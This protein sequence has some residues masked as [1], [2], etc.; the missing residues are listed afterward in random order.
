MEKIVRDSQCQ[1]SVAFV[2]FIDPKIGM[3]PLYRIATRSRGVFVNSALFE[4]F[5]LTILEASACGLPVVATKYGG[6]S[7]I[8]TNNVNGVLVNPKNGAQIENAL[9]RILNN[10][11]LWKKLS[12]NGIKNAASFSWSAMAKE[13]EKLFRRLIRN[14]AEMA[15]AHMFSN[16]SRRDPV[17]GD[18][19]D[20]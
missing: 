13:E 18:V 16:H 8:I 1:G 17:E 11:K 9:A 5:G 6:P 4:P 15:M 20:A 12:T 19:A 14:R 2:G 7:E 3:G 10:R